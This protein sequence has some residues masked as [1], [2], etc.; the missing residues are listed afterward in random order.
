ML[1]NIV[2]TS[3][4]SLVL[5]KILVEKGFKMGYVV[6]RSRQRATAFVRKLSQGIPITYDEDFLLKDIVFISVPDGVI[7]LV[8][9]NIKTR[10]S[11]DV[12]IYH[13]SGF[14]T[15]Y[16]FEDA[17]RF[18][19]GRGSIHPNLSFADE[20]IALK[21]IHRCCF[22][23]EGN[24]KG[25]SLARNIVQQISNC[26]IEIPVQAKMAYH[27]AAVLASNFSVGLAYLAQRL[28]DLYGLDGFEKIIPTLMLNTSRNVSKL[29]V[30]DSLT[31]PVARGDWVVVEKEQELFEKC[32]AKYKDLYANMVRVLKEIK[33][34]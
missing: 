1:I 18:G 4:V 11:D 7:D 3:K 13:F 34:R 33:G 24:E 12:N 6:S 19:W 14:L 21:S 20:K 9:S 17:D 30:K 28:Y 15:S 23:I 5:S 25:L 2:G 32:F 27:L 8:Y 29:G 16:I 26:W 10:L 31:G 22:G